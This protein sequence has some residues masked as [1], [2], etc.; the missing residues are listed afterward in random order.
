MKAL[1]IIGIIV[2][3]IVLAVIWVMII[4]NRVIFSLSFKGIDLSAFD[5][6]SLL[7]SGQ[8]EAKLLLNVNIQ[9]KNGFAIPFKEMKAWLYY[10]NTLI[11][12]TSGYLYAQSFNI[13]GNGHVDVSDYVN[14]HV[15]SASA[16]LVKSAVLKQNPSVNYTVKVSV[17][18]VPLTYS[19][20]FNASV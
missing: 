2:G 7:G 6:N 13:A 20:S 12:E 3:I 18:R 15:N 5:I 16:N 9:N 14:V 17:F 10:D 4:W 8:T 1:S 19:A 11:A